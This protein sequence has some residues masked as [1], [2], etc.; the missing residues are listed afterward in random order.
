MS[1]Y[2][3]VSSKGLCPL[4]REAGGNEEVIAVIEYKRHVLRKEL[5]NFSVL[6]FLFESKLIIIENPFGLVFSMKDVKSSLKATIGQILRFF[7][8]EYLLCWKN[9]VLLVWMD[10]AHW[11]A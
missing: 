5:A 4:T 6:T 1:L 11:H 8:V 7:L 10:L 3:N 2:Y 9:A